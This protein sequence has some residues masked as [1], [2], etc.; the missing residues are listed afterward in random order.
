M[1][2]KRLKYTTKQEFG[3]D[4]E[5]E[6]LQEL[7]ETLDTHMLTTC[8]AGYAQRDLMKLR[9]TYNFVVGHYLKGGG[10]TCR[11]EE[12]WWSSGGG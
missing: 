2:S 1:M 6:Q 7:K 11:G 8:N 5:P 3:S 9:N 4:S 12:V 10:L